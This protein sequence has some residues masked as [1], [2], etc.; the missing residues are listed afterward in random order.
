MKN[1]LGLD[2]GTNSI[3]WAWIQSKVPQQTDDC[4]SSSEYLMPDCATIRMAGSRVIPMDGS[5]L[6]DF[7]SGEAVSKTKE[8]TKHRMAR[9][10]NE[11]FQLR[12]ERL[13]RVLRILGFLP[14]HYAACLDRYGKIDE[15]KN[16]TIPWEPTADGKRKF[17]F[18]ASFLEMKERFHEHHPNLEKIPLDWTLYYLRTKALQQAI[19][20][21]ELAWVLHSFN[22][23][24]GYN[25]SR[26]EVKEVTKNEE[27]KEEEKK[28]YKNERVVSVVDSGEKK[29]G[30]TSYIVTTES[31]LQFTTENAA[32]PSWL[33]KELEFIVTTK[34]NP[35]GLPKM[36]QKGRIDCTVRIPKEEDW[37][38]KKKRTEA[39]IAD[40]H[41]T[42]GEYIFHSLLDN[43]DVKIKGAKVRTIDRHFYK[44]ELIAIL[45]KQAAFHPELKDA[46]RF[47]E[48]VSA[49][50]ASNE[51]HRNILSA[52][53]MPRLIVNDIIFYQRPLKSKK[54][55][56]AEC[57]FESRYFMDK[58]KKLQ[59]QGIKCIPTSHPHFQEYRIWQFLSN[60]RVLRR[61]VRENGRYMTDVNVSA[62][63]LTDKVK[64]ELY[65]WL[66]GKANV[67]QEEL[68]SQLQM[69]EK[70]FRW[71]YV[72][73]NIYPCGETRSLLSTRLKKAKLPLSLLDSPSSD[74]AHTFEFELWHI[75]YSVS[76][77]AELRKALRRFARKHDFTAEQQEAFVE[78]F[79]KCPPF[80]KDYGAYSDK[81]LVKLL[82]LM[83]I[84]KYWNADR[85]DAN[86]RRRIAC[87][88]DGE[89]CD[90]ISLRTRE[91]VAERGLQQSIEQFQGL[92]Q[93]LACYVVYDRHAE[94]SE[95]VRWESP[96]DLQQFTRQF[97]QYSLRNPIVEQVVLETLR[98]VHDLWEEIQKDGGTIDEIHLEMG[99]DLKNS[100]EQ[101]KKIK[102]RNLE[103]EKT[104]FR[105]K[106]LLQELH[107][108]Q[109]DIEG[110]RPYSPSQQE[111]LRLYEETVWESENGKSGGK[112]ASKGIPDDIKKIRKL[113]SEPSDKPIPQSSILRY[114]LWLDQKYLS[115]Y[116]GRPIPLARLF[117]A[118]YEIE[119]IIPRSIFFDDSYANKVICESAV[120]KLKNNRLG[121]QFIREMDGRV[122]TV[123]LG[124]GRETSILSVNGYVDLVNDLFRNN[125][126]KRNNLLAEEITED[127]CHRQLSDTR[128]IARYIKGILSNIVRQR[129]ADGTLEQ[130]ATSKNLIVCTGQITDRVKQDW[131]LNDVWNHI[132]TPR[133]ERL[134]R[135]TGS[136]DYGEWCCKEGKRYFQT[137]VPL[138]LQIGFNKKRIDHRH[139]A[140]DAI[141]IA[142]VNRNV[143]NYLN[144]AAAHA[145]DRM[146]LRMRICRP[147]GNGQTKREIRS[148]W[149]N[150][151]H[152]AECA[153][154]RIVVSF[155]QNL[156][157]LTKAT[158]TYEGYDV[159]GKKVRRC[160]TS[161]DHYSIRKPLHEDTV[162]GETVQPVVNQVSL[163]KALLQ[164]NRI[165]DGKLRKKIQEMQSSGLT[166]KQIVNHFKKTCADSPEWSHINFEKIGVRAYSNEVGQKRKVAIRKVIDGSFTEEKIERITDVSIQRILLNHL[167]ECNGDSKVA[168]SPE[169]IDAM[170]RNIFR[171]NGDKPHL[172]IYKVRLGKVLGKKFAVGQRGNKGKKFVITA[173]STNLFFAVYANDEGKRSFETIDLHCAIEMQKQGKDV[174]PSINEKGDKL[175]FVLSP[176]DLVYVPSESELQHG[177]D[178]NDLKLDHVFKVVSCQDNTIYFIPNSV[179][180]PIAP[181]F[182]FNKKNKVETVSNDGIYKQGS[183]KLSIKNICLPIKMDRL[184]HL[185]LVKI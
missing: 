15:E 131:G 30:K 164:V 20:K 38:L 4:P 144:N 171:L 85:I 35:T 79:V 143:V 73:D 141:A 96:A 71:N 52:W 123:K 178:S 1:I 51:M 118:D 98:V 167:R 177:V 31:N 10:V 26:N 37:E 69:S 133:F 7:K 103:N 139:H 13:N 34:L 109:P 11:R 81:A 58:E 106:L 132:I 94:A 179:A 32:A 2:L 84:G 22:Q 154:Q 53:D 140:M 70:E 41:M 46:E 100:A 42:V 115:P 80:K 125:P 121:M 155:K 62:H 33:D 6:S 161:S 137:R 165:V 181:E 127:F 17:L 57:P 150:F 152:D 112:E 162:Y 21:E 175:L 122:E 48:C 47:A 107:D 44:E 149:K 108:C 74:G 87:L 147:S 86:T 72:E 114:R 93:S 78:T 180:S 142:C 89:A 68:L 185:H 39:L 76:D 157:I 128:Y 116:T 82:S 12:R 64:V 168:F 9:R 50:Y 138:H 5:L 176:N 36:N 166:D 83:R 159:S 66:A 163:K 136:N 124:E 95:V 145:T 8:R 170:N 113:L 182:E 97:K 24:R 29:K 119:H 153:L 134:N 63:Y 14:A 146:D 183:E 120:N 65:E 49:L 28:E 3:G 111:L 92:P 105:I 110:I 67:K 61:E 23:K 158:N 135:M 77:L 156:R 55:D 148:P 117:T 102:D 75:L 101:R 27:K 126:R 18:Y 160:Q 54:S 60:L 172:P 174:A 19:T 43:P 40:S 151:A 104:N 184:G 59:K 25:Q 169:G 173:Q 129:A 16:V 56:I 130:E 90:S 91:K 99:R 45:N 88:L